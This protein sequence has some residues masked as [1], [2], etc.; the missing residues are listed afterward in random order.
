MGQ[1][2]VDPSIRCSRFSTPI[3]MEFSRPWRSM[4][5]RPSSRQHDANKDG[6]LTADE[7]RPAFR[8]GPGGPGGRG[9][10][11]PEGI[12]GGSGPQKPPLAKDEGEKRILEALNTARSG[13]R[14]ANVS[15]ADGR[16]LRQ[17]AESIGTGGLSNWGR[18]LV[19]PVSGSR[20]LSA[21]REESST[22][23]ISTQDGSRSPARTSSGPGWMTS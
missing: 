4:R 23:T 14:F 9:R 22:P 6:K 16:L 11:G 12:A 5:R 18:P 7:I 13:E 19:N 2:A 3:M 8:G 17:L 10:G 20:S 1:D 15:E 21:R